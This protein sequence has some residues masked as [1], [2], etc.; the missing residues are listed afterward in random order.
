MCVSHRIIVVHFVV[1]SMNIIVTFRIQTLY[2][3]S[4]EF[5]PQKHSL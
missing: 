5:D 1:K 2:R 3:W 4:N